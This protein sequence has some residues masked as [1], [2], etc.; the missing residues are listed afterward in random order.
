MI[1]GRTIVGN[2]S[3]FYFKSAV[4]NGLELCDNIEVGACST[5]TKKIEQPGLYVGTPAR[6]IGDV[7]E[8]NV[9]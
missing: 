7:K 8:K 1:A 6:R 4:F 5:V 2:N 3:T 9:Q